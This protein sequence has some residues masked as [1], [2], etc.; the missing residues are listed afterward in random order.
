MKSS[1]TSLGKKPQNLNP[2]DYVSV[3]VIPNHGNVLNY[4]LIAILVMECILEAF[5]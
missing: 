1:A 4:V 3:G 2:I 5:P